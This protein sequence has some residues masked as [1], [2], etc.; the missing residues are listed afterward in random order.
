VSPWRTGD[1][2][3]RWCA[4]ALLHLEGDFR[5]VKGYKQLA[6]LQ[7]V[8]APKIMSVSSAAT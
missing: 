3:P 5:R 1:Q 6:L 4:A 8:L 7:C 2:K